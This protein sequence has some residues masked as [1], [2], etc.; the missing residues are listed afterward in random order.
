MTPPAA[1]TVPGSGDAPP[2]LSEHERSVLG[3]VVYSCTVSSIRHAKDADRAPSMAERGEMLRMS[4]ERVAALDGLGALAASVGAD[5][6]AAAEPFMEALGDFDQ[7]LRPLDWAERLL[8]THLALGLLADFCRALAAG[9]SEPLRSGLGGALVE[10]RF[11]RF[12]ADALVPGIDSDPQLAGRLGL[13]GRRVVGEEIGT[14]QRMLAS[15]PPLLDGAAGLE[16]VHAVLSEG[17]VTRMR[18]LGLRD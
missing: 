2:L 6:A 1:A 7:R 4:A 14:L 17:A 15:F 9:L 18:S 10:D 13:W 11:T 16:D 5:A 3:V 12:A 8:K